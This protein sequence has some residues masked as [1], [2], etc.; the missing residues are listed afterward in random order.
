VTVNAPQFVVNSSLYVFC[1]SR[2]CDGRLEPPSFLADGASAELQAPADGSA[3]VAGAASVLVPEPLPHP[4]TTKR[5]SGIRMAADLIAR[6][7][8][9]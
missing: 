2:R 1:G 9:A 7:Y 4:V 8:F 5:V 3:V 6:S